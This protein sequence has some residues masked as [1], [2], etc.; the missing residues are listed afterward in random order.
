MNEYIELKKMFD[1]VTIVREGE[2][3]SITDHRWDSNK[4][5]VINRLAKEGWKVVGYIDESILMERE[6]MRL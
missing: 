4:I 5:E 6:I 1:K 2:V 3:F